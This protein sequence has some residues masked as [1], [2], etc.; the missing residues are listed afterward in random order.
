[1]SHCERERVVNKGYLEKNIENLKHVL[2][3]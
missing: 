1:M 3:T 2:K